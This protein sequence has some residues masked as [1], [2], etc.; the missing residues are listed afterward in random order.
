MAVTSESEKNLPSSHGLIVNRVDHGTHIFVTKPNSKYCTQITIQSLPWRWLANLRR[1][2]NSFGD[3]FFQSL[4]AWNG[5]TSIHF[6][7]IH[8]CLKIFEELFLGRKK[9]RCIT[10]QL[11][12]L[13]RFFK[14]FSFLLLGLGGAYV[15]LTVKGSLPE[16]GW[17]FQP[18]SL[19]ES[20]LPKKNL[21]KG[22]HVGS[23]PRTCSTW[24]E[25]H[26]DIML[27]KIR[28]IQPPFVFAMFLWSRISEP[29]T[30]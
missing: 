11:Y 7:A 9:I 6:I 16:K 2:E 5:N 1:F 26:N 30:S 29:S 10:W 25:T 24:M 15:K 4:G 28:H 13:W 17:I 21:F 18:F 20:R 27:K 23:S 22:H 14:T 12:R 8:V 3:F 19:T